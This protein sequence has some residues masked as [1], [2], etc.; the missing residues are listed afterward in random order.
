MVSPAV[1]AR[2]ILL[3]LTFVA[4]WNAVLSFWGISFANQ[5]WV[6]GLS[7]GTVA[8]ICEKAVIAPILKRPTATK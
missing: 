7:S 1:W 5:D 3:M 8:V 4:I 2:E 6:I